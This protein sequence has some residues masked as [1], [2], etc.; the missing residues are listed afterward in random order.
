MT[1]QGA[2]IS[3]CDGRTCLCRVRDF[4]RSGLFSTANGAQNPSLSQNAQE[5]IEPGKLAASQAQE[6]FKQNKVGES[7]EL[8]EVAIK[9]FDARSRQ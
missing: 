3:V 5:A 6:A 8:W 9:D 4:G 2:W 1:R 7:Q